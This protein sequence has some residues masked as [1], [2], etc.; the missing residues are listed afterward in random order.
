MSSAAEPLIH[1]FS[2]AEPLIHVDL[3]TYLQT[4]CPIEPIFV[5]WVASMH[6]GSGIRNIFED[7]RRVYN[8]VWCF[9]TDEEILVDEDDKGKGSSKDKGKGSSKDKGGSSSKDGGS[10]SKDG[11]AVGFA[12]LTMVAKVRLTNMMGT[13]VQH[14]GNTDG[15]PLRQKITNLMFDIDRL[16]DDIDLGFPWESRFNACKARLD[17]LNREVRLARS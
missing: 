15:L 10:S 6:A 8:G 14:L 3:F 16:R 9:S 2:A 17:E 1:V 4:H 13:L 11:V 5:G 12:V 7:P